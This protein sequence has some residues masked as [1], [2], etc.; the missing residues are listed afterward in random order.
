MSHQ[1][2]QQVSL[3]IP[4]SR[5]DGKPDNGA[6]YVI[7]ALVERGFRYVSGDVLELE[8]ALGTERTLR[9]VCTTPTRD[10]TYWIPRLVR[11]FQELSVPYSEID[12]AH[13]RE[14]TALGAVLDAATGR[15]ALA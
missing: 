5:F 12:A 8:H 3:T 10:R 11:V 7:A 1:P 13:E 2:S 4:L 6:L 9:L 14:R 15:H